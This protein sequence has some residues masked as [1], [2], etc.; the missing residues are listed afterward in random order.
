MALFLNFLKKQVQ[1]L[2]LFSMKLK[3]SY[4]IPVFS[5]AV[6]EDCKT[7]SKSK[8]F[9]LK[10]KIPHKIPVFSCAVTQD[11]ESIYIKQLQIKQGSFCS[12]PTAKTL[13][14]RYIW[15]VLGYFCPCWSLEHLRHLW[16][17]AV[18]QGVQHVITTPQFLHCK[19]L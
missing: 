19:E 13:W 18:Q 7:S 17:P 12:T 11:Y 16:I 3:I 6:C 8:P 10:L 15:G 5:Y 2:S 1:S 4:K 9:S 14:N